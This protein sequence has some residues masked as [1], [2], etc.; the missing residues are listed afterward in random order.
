MFQKIFKL[1]LVEQNN[2]NYPLN[3]IERTIFIKKLIDI[4]RYID[5]ENRNTNNS[6]LSYYE[7]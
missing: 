3:N 4:F 5:I 1:F 7:L 2:W 6:D